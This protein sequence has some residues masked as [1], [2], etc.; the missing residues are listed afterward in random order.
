MSLRI[1]RMLYAAPSIP[2]FN[3]YKCHCCM[4]T[5]VGRKACLSLK[6]CT[7][8]CASV[9]VLG[10]A[11]TVRCVAVLWLTVS[12]FIVCPQVIIS[13]LVSIVTPGM[14]VKVRVGLI[15]CSSFWGLAVWLWLYVQGVIMKQSM[16][17]I[18]ELSSRNWQGTIPSTSGCM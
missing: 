17:I 7:C 11:I 14:G 6:L 16:W 18:I 9:Y 4:Y 12:N 10:C 13:H 3:L 1:S 5:I 8:M 2:L 15:M